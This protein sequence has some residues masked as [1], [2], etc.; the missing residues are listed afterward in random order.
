[1]NNTKV[2]FITRAGLIGALYVALIF[3]TFS[4]A[5]GF[6][7][8]RLA[9]ALCILPLFYVEAVPGL[10]IG[11]MV[12]NFISGATLIDIILG[13]LITLISAILTY[14]VGKLIKGDRPLIK[15]IIGG[16]FPV[17]LNATLLPIIWYFAYGGFEVYYFYNFLSLLLS[18]SFSI[19]VLGLFVNTGVRK[20]LKKQSTEES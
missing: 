2:K 15:F 12:A 3:P 17:I 19:Y 10:F 16:F 20:M 8:I 6:F 11:C 18:Q 5:S 13:A 9:E 7:Q 1:M 14:L 4:L